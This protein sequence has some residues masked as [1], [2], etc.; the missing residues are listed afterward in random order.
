MRWV[1]ILWI[2]SI[3]HKLSRA[4]WWFSKLHL[5]L[6]YPLCDP[7]ESYA[8]Y[9]ILG[10]G[11]L[12]AGE[13]RWFSDPFLM[14]AITFEAW[15]YSY[16][17]TLTRQL[18]I[19]FHS[20]PI[21]IPPSLMEIMRWEWK[22]VYLIWLQSKT[23]LGIFDISSASLSV[24]VCLLVLFCWASLLHSIQHNQLIF[25]KSRVRRWWSMK[26]N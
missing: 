21:P 11:L 8:T 24:M 18:Q 15:N 19:H 25:R 16:F 7:S 14:H 2:D 12:L 4:D 3:D 9:G 10:R 6:P 20:H 5:N 22:C 1:G 26:S 13:S 23:I 17:R